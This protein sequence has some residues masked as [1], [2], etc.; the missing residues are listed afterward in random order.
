MLEK[1]ARTLQLVRRLGPLGW[2][3]SLNQ[4][5]T[6]SHGA[7]VLLGVSCFSLLLRVVDLLGELCLVIKLPLISYI[8][9]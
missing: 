4:F 2:N 9:A 1:W 3:S 5:V 6:A 8:A 7:K